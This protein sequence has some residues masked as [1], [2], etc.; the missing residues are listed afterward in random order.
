MGYLNNEEKVKETIDEDGWIHTGDVGKVDQ[1]GFFYITGRIKEI[2]IT[3][4]GENVAPVP[5]EENIKENL[6]LVSQAMVIGDKRKF[7]SVLLTLQVVIDVDTG[8]P[9]EQLTALA[10]KYCKDLGVNATTAKEIA[11]DVPE[12]LSKAITDAIGV[13]NKKAT[14]NACKVQKWKLLPLDFTTTGGELGPTQ[15]LR[16][17]Q[18]GKMYHDII[19]EFYA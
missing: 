5:I 8:A 15:K 10:Q 17:P 16:R 2:L 6:P 19:E 4:G 7:L 12:A 14:S 3:A 1:D 18:V 11:P 13:A 9:T